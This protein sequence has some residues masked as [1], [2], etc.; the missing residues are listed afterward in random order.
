MRLA[1]EPTL[2]T[3]QTFLS[4]SGGSMLYPPG[5]TFLSSAAAY[6]AGNSTPS[7]PSMGVRCSRITSA[8]KAS[9]DSHGSNLAASLIG[10]SS[11]WDRGK[12]ALQVLRAV[13]QPEFKEGC[14]C[15]G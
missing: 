1:C 15:D 13:Q 8:A 14:A 5:K 7:G 3:R 4:P 6:V 12:E 11:K 2:S 10:T 9:L